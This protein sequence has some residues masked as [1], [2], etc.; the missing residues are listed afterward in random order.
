MAL[1]FQQLR[2]YQEDKAKLFAL[3]Q[4]HTNSD[5]AWRNS[6]HFQNFIHLSESSSFF[7][8]FAQG[9]MQHKS[10]LST[11]LPL[12][13]GVTIQERKLQQQQRLTGIF[14]FFPTHKSSETERGQQQESLYCIHTI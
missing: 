9:T 8:C 10:Y 11:L 7:V 5:R 12:E 1:V 14:F 4:R 6:I 2:G 3:V 13:R